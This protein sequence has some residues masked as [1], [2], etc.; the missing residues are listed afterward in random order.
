MKKAFNII[1]GLA[2]L[3]FAAASCQKDEQPVKVFDQTI[4]GQW[5]LVSA[6]AEGSSIMK[7]IDVYL[8]ID[9][10]GNF[11]LYQKTGNQTERYDLYTGI[12]ETI[13]GVLTGV[14]SDGKPWGGKYI[15]TKTGDSLVLKTTNDIEEQQYTSCQIPD[16]VRQDA[17]TIYTKAASDAGSPI[18]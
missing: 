6:I 17:N 16:A 8:S 4:A 11:E 14:Y 3:V 12:C 15:Y 18:L 13:N 1:I 9:N 5:H 10:A 2:A 7:D